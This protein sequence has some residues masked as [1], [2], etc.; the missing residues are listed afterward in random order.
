MVETPEGGL[1]R[2]YIDPDYRAT[3][4]YIR[5]FDLCGVASFVWLWLQDGDVRTFWP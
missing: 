1:H 5:S 4:L 2:E 3:R